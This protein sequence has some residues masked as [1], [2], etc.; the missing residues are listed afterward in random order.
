MTSQVKTFY[1]N[2]E[3]RGKRGR[4]RFQYELR[5]MKKEDVI[6]QIYATVGSQHKI[7]RKK[8]IINEIKE[9]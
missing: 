6:E 1:I 8:I 4:Q 2:G 7:S 9:I 5:G 3:F